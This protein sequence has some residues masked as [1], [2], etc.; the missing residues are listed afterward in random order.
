MS[1]IDDRRL[2]LVCGCTTTGAPSGTRSWRRGANRVAVTDEGERAFG[3][4]PE[5]TNINDAY[6]SVVAVTDDGRRLWVQ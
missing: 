2:Y 4:Y 1:S 3:P 5:E 6:W